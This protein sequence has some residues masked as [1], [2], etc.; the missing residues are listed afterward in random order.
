VTH[1]NRPIPTHSITN[2]APGFLHGAAIHNDTTDTIKYTHPVNGTHISH[3]VP[4]MH[5]RVDTATKSGRTAA[6][7]IHE[8]SPDVETY[9][10]LPV[11]C[12]PATI[13]DVEQL[14]IIETHRTSNVPYQGHQSRNPVPEPQR[15]D[16]RVSEQFTITPICCGEGVRSLASSKTASVFLLNSVC[17]AVR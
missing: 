3:S 11:T 10:T 17:P 5:E 9:L 12:R 8:N 6:P 7:C 2:S 13:L 4:I 14:P 15:R 16:G 1:S